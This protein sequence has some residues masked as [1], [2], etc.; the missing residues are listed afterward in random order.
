V[1][2]LLI[3]RADA[4]VTLGHEDGGGGL[5][6]NHDPAKTLDQIRDY[7][8]DYEPWIQTYIRIARRA[9]LKGFSWEPALQRELEHLFFF[10]SQLTWEPNLSWGELARRY[11]LRS[12][13]RVDERLVEAYRLALEANAGVTH[14]GMAA[15][16]MGTAQRVVQ[17]QGLLETAYVRERVAALGEVLSALGLADVVHEK[18]PVAFDLKRSLVKAWKRMKAGQVLGQWH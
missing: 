7:F 8:R 3:E 10:T 16:E 11:V 14:W 17:T 12:E 1:G 15:Y 13:R 6:A 9:G 5:E 2:N 4:P 18:P